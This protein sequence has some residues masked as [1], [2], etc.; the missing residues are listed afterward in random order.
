M[1]HITS[2]EVLRADVLASKERRSPVRCAF[3]LYAGENEWI[4][5][6]AALLESLKDF[7]QVCFFPDI[8]RHHSVNFSETVVSPC[9]E[10]DG[11][12]VLPMKDQRLGQLQRLIQSVTKFQ[13]IQ[14]SIKL[15][16]IQF[17]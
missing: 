1:I 13:I 14:L 10:G 6:Y 16:S 4:S 12:T 2:G 7:P 5:G 17:S 3:V 11:K 8:Y 15:F 9:C